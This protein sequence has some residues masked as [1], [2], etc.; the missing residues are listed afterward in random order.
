MEKLH[1][2]DGTQ[3]HHGTKAFCLILWYCC[4]RC[5]Y[6][7]MQWIVFHPCAHT[8][9]AHDSF[10]SLNTVWWRC[11]TPSKHTFNQW[12]HSCCCCCC[13]SHGCFLH[14]VSPL[15]SPIRLSLLL[16]SIVY[17]VRFGK[18]SDMRCAFLYWGI[19]ARLLILFSILFNAFTTLCV[20]Q[21]CRW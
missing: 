7:T 20:L 19:E 13:L 9:P 14:C 15:C 21:Q 18:T 12:I 8:Q 10:E 2:S 11:D 6:Y 16:S 5:T 1:V 4:V 17:F 3:Q